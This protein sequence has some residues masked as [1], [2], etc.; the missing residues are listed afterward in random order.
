MKILIVCSQFETGGATRVATVMCNGFWG[1]G[2]EVI[3]VADCT[4]SRLTYPLNPEIPILPLFNHKNRTGRGN[5]LVS[6]LEAVLNIRGYIKEYKPNVIIAVEAYMYIR[7]C[8]ANF[9]LKYP[10]IVADHTSFDRD[11]DWLINLTRR[12]LY[13]YADGLS[14]L[15]EKDKRKLGD[16][17]P[18]KEVI[19]NP[20][21]FPPLD[22]L[23]SRRKNILC[24]GRL[25]VWRLKGFDTMVELWSQIAEKF[26]NW[27]LEIAGSGAQDSVAYIENMIYKH[28]LYGRVKLL[29]NVKDMRKLYQ[30]TSIFAL[31]S[32]VEGFPMVLL[33]ALSQGCACIAF[34]IQGATNEMI[35][36]G[37]GLVIED[38]DI[39]AFKNNLVEL[40]NNEEKRDDLS[41]KAIES[42]RKFSQESFINHWVNYITKVL[43]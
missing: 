26:P 9:L 21:P 24:V 35:E 31:P 38:G 14:I 28:N 13:K 43:S 40:M 10:V 2:I 19:Y 39:E 36:T 3:V 41:K 16:K 4:Y 30:E 18:Q 23:T 37:A 42:V 27:T 6:S 29:G 20:L 5:R 11:M 33:E 32:R 7:V 25:D 8:L 22:C 34:A 15:T 12:H 17:F 1:K